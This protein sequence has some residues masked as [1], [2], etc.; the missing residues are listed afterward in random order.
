MVAVAIGVLALTI[1]GAAIA[2]T[3]SGDANSITTNIESTVTVAPGGSGTGKF[4]LVVND[5]AT[6]P[7]NGCNAQ[8]SN[9]VVLHIASNRSWLTLG[10]SSISLA[11]CDDTGA[12]G[13]QNAANV[14][15][16]VATNAPASDT[17]TVTATYQSGGKA[18][19]SYTSGSFSI[20][21]PATVNT[22]PTTPGMPALAAGSNTPNAGVFG[23]VWT[24]STDAQNDPITY[25]LEHKDA[26][27]FSFSLV[28]GRA[29]RRPLR[30]L[31]RPAP[32]RRRELGRIRCGPPT[33]A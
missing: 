31:S 21:T 22:A 30:S 10:A 6:D 8:T 32:R 11:A 27:D 5:N 2:D 26:N 4:A 17:A 29:R 23:L 1:A 12:A 24:A 14:G 9:P 15:Y 19:G 33:A 28:P 7:A 13:L 20:Q 18:G 25:R 3:I 16:T